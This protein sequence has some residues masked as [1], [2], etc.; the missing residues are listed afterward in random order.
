MS[1]ESYT[2]R[3]ARHYDER[4][5]HGDAVKIVKELD[6][7]QKYELYEIVCKKLRESSHGEKREKEFK[8]LKSVL[9][10][11]KSLDTS[12]LHKARQGRSEMADDA[13]SR[14]GQ[15]TVIRKKV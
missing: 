8:A 1:R 11:D 15:T 12:R 9:E 13:R 4:N 14:D 3:E 2:R 5:Y 10:K 7:Y 6:K